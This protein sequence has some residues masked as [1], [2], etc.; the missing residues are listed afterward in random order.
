MIRIK[1]EEAF[2]GHMGILGDPDVFRRWILSGY[3]KKREIVLYGLNKKLC[4]IKDAARMIGLSPNYAMRRYFGGCRYVLIE[5]DNLI[6]ERTWLLLSDVERVVE[7]YKA[8]K[9]LK[10]GGR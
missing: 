7:R 6:T 1:F 9:G 5:G 3:G 8:A 10:A 4:T 2:P